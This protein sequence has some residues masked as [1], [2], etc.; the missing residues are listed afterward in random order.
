MIKRIVFLTTVVILSD[1]QPQGYHWH[2]LRIR[3]IGAGDETDWDVVFATA[4]DARVI[5]AELKTIEHQK[6][7]KDY[8]LKAVDLNRE[9]PDVKALL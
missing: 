1:E 4:V 9:H 8:S 3:L 7:G 2:S 6:S 5:S